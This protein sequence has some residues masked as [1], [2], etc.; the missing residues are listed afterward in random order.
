MLLKKRGTIEIKQ[1]VMFFSVLIQII[2]KNIKLIARSRSS[3]LIVLL[4]PLIVIALVGTAYNTSNIYDIRIGAYAESY[5]DLAESLIDTLGGQQFSVIKFDSKDNCVNSLKAAEIHVCALIPPNLAPGTIEPIDFYVDQSRVNLVWIIIDAVSSK[6]STK[7]TELSLQMTSA[8]LGTL[9]DTNT[10]LSQKESSIDQLQT[11]NEEAITLISEVSTS[12]NSI[13]TDV[14]G[15]INLGK[16]SEKLEE[17][18]DANNL[19]SEAFD[20]VYAT[21]TNIKNN[22]EALGEALAELSIESSAKLTSAI[23]TLDSS[24]SQITDL[25]ETF[26][27]IKTNIVS[28]TG[29]S[30]ETIVSPLKTHVTPIVTEKTHL[31]F[32]FPTLLVLVV[33]LI[34][35]LLSSGLVIKEKL[36]AS[37]FRNYISPT[38]NWI[39]ILAH[40]VTN[41]LI[42]TIQLII[43]FAVALIFFK[44]ALLIVL[45]EAVLAL[46]PIISIFILTGMLIGFIFKSEETAMLTTVCVASLFLFFSSTILPLEALP[47]YLKQIADYNPFVVSESLLKKIMLFKATLPEVSYLFIVLIGYTIILAIITFLVGKWVTSKAQ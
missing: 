34:S 37:Y 16:I 5:S 23:N 2:K 29:T 32:L 42:L 1:R 27:N 18:I 22:T 28:A 17:T 43:L 36:S 19:T 26:S 7:T 44:S 8:I 4:G 14:V 6:V 20:P 21:I 12:I 31:N 35:L 3:A 24:S 47:T 41:F 39:F 13:D 38:K 10:Q 33:M 30:A 9:T 46:I 45:W 11:G 15:S 40:F 25:E